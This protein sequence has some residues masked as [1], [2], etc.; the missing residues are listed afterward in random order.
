M[1]D[2]LLNCEPRAVQIEAL[3]RSYQGFARQDAMGAPFTRPLALPHAGAAAQGWGH[4]LEMRLGK[5]PVALNEYLL[6][7]REHGIHRAV[8]LAPNKFK[9]TWAAEA[10]RFGVHVPVHVYEAARA[11]RHYEGF[12]AR[13]ERAGAGLL[14]ANYEAIIAANG[15]HF[16]R[17]A[18]FADDRPFLLVLDE[19][20]VVKNPR[21]KMSRA[22]LRLGKA[23]AYR[24]AL[25]GMP[26]PYAPYD[27][28]NQFRVLGTLGDHSNFYAFKHTFTRMGGFQGKQALGIQ[29][30]EIL[31]RFLRSRCF[32]AK[33][34]DWGLTLGVDYE[35]VPLEMTAAQKDAYRRM[36]R[37]LVLWL[38]E[39]NGAVVAENVLAKHMKLQQIASGFIYGENGATVDIMPFEK[40]PKFIDL[41]D[42]LDNYIPG[43]VIVIAH[44][45]ATLRNLYRALKPQMPAF[46]VGGMKSEDVEREKARFNS[47]DDCRI[48]LGQGQAIK[49]GHTLIGSDARPCYSI[50][51][52]ENDYNL[53]TRTQCEARPQ[54]VHQQVPV[55]IWDYHSCA[56]EKKITKALQKRQKIS[57]VIMGA[58]RS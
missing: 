35:Q 34:T 36:E 26:A 42:R 6:L 54:G 57:A 2:W 22:A 58:Y 39:A 30:A 43:K 5:T 27:L 17:I 16:D 9:A 28:W 29:N 46:I 21:S 45:R 51:F 53:D 3:S 13:S 10:E 18:A 20:A 1:I 4:F 11:A 23:A 52:F 55:H 33:K 38:G 31:D 44:Y 49:Y 48:M 37:D 15:K 56:I 41:K 50:C 32:R 19:S 7:Q 40:T 47:D 12:L 14:I 24:R 8:V 25:S